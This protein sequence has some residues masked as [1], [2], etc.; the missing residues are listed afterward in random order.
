MVLH[1]LFIELDDEG[2]EVFKKDLFFFALF[3]FALD[4][5]DFG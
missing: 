2:L 1:I 5:L 3:V 4:S